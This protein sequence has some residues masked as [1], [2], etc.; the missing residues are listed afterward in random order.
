MQ[1]EGHPCRTRHER[2]KLSGRSKN[3]RC[4]RGGVPHAIPRTVL[5]T[6]LPACG[7]TMSVPSVKPLR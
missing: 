1:G 5:R 7:P 2:G 6:F 3:A 4:T